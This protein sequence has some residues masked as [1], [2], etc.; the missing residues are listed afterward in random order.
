M[1]E[2]SPKLFI[3]RTTVLQPSACTDSLVHFSTMTTTTATTKPFPT[4]WCRL[5]GLNDVIV[6]SYTMSLERP[7]KFV[8]YNGLT[9]SFSW[10]LSISNY[11]VILHLI[12]SSYWASNC[13]ILSRPNHLRRNSAIFFSIGAMPA[14]FFF[15]FFSNARF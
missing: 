3:C 6:L 4:R 2:L 15:S 14:F 7:F 10:F 11:W 5:Y 8:F 9:Y 1:W 13:L 12:Y